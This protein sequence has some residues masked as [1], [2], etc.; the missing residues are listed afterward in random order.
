[1]TNRLIRNIKARIRAKRYLIMPE[2]PKH[3]LNEGYWIADDVI[4][5]RH[6]LFIFFV[7]A[8]NEWYHKE[9]ERR[10]TLCACTG[11]VQI[12]T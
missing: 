9:N 2:S 12:F 6:P 3:H 11:Y 7:S 4:Y 10:N 8:Q 1:M 5:F